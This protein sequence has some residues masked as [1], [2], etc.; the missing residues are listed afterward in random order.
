MN[1]IQAAGCRFL[2]KSFCQEKRTYVVIRRMAPTAANRRTYYHHI[3]LLNKLLSF[4]T[5][6]TTFELEYP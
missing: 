1:T 4:T 5:G 3:T 2:T 6:N